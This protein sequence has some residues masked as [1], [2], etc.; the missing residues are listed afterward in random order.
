MPKTTPEVHLGEITAVCPDSTGE[1]LTISRNA[2]QLIITTSANH[3]FFN[4]PEAISLQR[5]IDHCAIALR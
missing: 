3:L 2:G 1:T 5:E 4:E